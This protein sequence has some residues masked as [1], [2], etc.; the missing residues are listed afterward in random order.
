MREKMLL[1]G[2]KSLRGL[3]TMNALNSPCFVSNDLIGYYV[4]AERKRIYR[5]EIEKETS[6]KRGYKQ[7]QWFN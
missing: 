7:C 1:P 3:D 4:H 6:A 5:D 2:H